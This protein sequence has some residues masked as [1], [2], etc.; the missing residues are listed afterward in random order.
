MQEDGLQDAPD[1]GHIPC[2]GHDVVD[3]EG[4][5]AGREGGD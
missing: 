5:G 2:G 4:A 1:L 3:G